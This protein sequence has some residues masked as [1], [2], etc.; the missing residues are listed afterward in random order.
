MAELEPK[1]VEVIVEQPTAVVPR[2]R[3][4]NVYVG[5]SGPLEIG[6]VAAGALVLVTVFMIYFVWVVPSNRELAFNRSE[7]DRLEAEL[8]SAKSKYGEITSTQ[9]EVG[10]LVASVDDFETRFLPLASNGQSAALPEAERPDRS[11]WP[12]EYYRPRLCTA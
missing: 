10:R 9:S 2:V 7:A 6:A 8:I 11:L 1:P 12:G 4:R 3:A 5:M